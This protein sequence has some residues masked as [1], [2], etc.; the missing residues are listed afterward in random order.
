MNVSNIINSRGKPMRNQYVFCV[1]GLETFQSY[2]TKIATI[3]SEGVVTLSLES[4]DYSATT[5]KALKLF[6]NTTETK[7]EIQAKINSGEYKTAEF[8]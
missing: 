5:L 8:D 7:K 2:N 6:L 3:D 1:N 4:W